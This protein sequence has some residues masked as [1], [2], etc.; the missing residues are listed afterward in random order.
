MHD[1]TRPER[2]PSRGLALDHG[3]DFAMRLWVRGCR[4]E[5]ATSDKSARVSS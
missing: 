3:S 5:K 4:A 1:V 2:A